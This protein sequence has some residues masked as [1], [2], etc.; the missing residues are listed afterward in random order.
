M[1]THGTNIG[2]NVG[3]AAG[4][5]IPF[6]LHLHVLPRWWGDTNF[7]PTLADIKQISTDM[8]RIYDELR[9]KIEQI[10]LS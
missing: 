10:S 5:G 1:N 6:H 7:L 9:P 3:K 4:A 8:N 2:L